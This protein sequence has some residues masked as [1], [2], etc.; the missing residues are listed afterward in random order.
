M[1]ADAVASWKAYVA[2]ADA[3]RGGYGDECALLVR[4]GLGDVVVAHFLESAEREFAAVH[5]PRLKALLEN[6]GAANISRTLSTAAEKVGNA[7]DDENEW[8]WV[9]EAVPRG[10]AELA[11]AVDERRRRAAR[12]AAAM[13]PSNKNDAD[14]ATQ[15]LDRRLCAAVGAATATVGPREMT[16]VCAAYYARAL[17]EFSRRARRARGLGDDDDSEED[18]DDR[19]VID[20]DAMEPT[21]RRPMPAWHPSCEDVMGV[22]WSRALA[23]VAG[24]LRAVG[25]GEGGASDVA[26]AALHRALETAARVKVRDVAAGDFDKKALPSLLRWLDATPLQFARCA[27]GLD[28]AGTAEWRG[29]LEYAIYERLGSLRIDEFFNVIVEFPDSLPAVDDL[30]RCLRRTTL[31]DRLTSSLRGALQRRLLIPGAPTSDIIEQYRLTIRALRAL[32]PSGVVLSVVSAP[33]KEYLRERKD[34][35][36]CVVTMLMGARDGADEL[37]GADE[38]DAM[39]VGDGDGSR[40]I[41]A[42][43]EE[44]EG[45]PEFEA[46]E[47]GRDGGAGRPDGGGGGG[48]GGADGGADGGTDGD[49]PRRRAA[50]GRGWD[51]WEPE[52]VESEA[53]SSRGR[54]RPVEDELGHLI[55]IYGSK[56]LFINEYRNMLAERLLSKVGYDVT[57]EMHTLELLKI[58]FGEASLHKCEVMLKDVLDSKRINGNVKAPPAPGTPAARDTASTNILQNSPLDATIVSALFWPPFAN[59]APDFKLPAEMKNMIDAYS[60]R[61]HHLKAPRQLMWRPTL[62]TVEVEVMRGELELQL[63]VSTMEAAVLSHFQRKD[64]WGQDELAAEMGINRATLRRKAVVWINQGLLVEE[65]NEGPDGSSYRLTTGDDGRVAFGAAAADD[66]GGGG[67]AVASAEDQA[68]AGMK[69]YEQYVI[70]M[71][72][73]FPSLPP[74]RIHNMLKMFVQDPPYDRSLDQL[75]AFLGQLVAEDKLALEGNQYSKR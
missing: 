69:V 48:D 8:S 68:A 42:P 70:G 3:D 36:R 17:K 64:R 38:D 11:A 6:H 72:T 5:L 47:D 19:I 18:D 16:G 45:D 23:S 62:G 31:H 66:E 33:L 25:G 26:E 43:P 65:K 32:D 60:K 74:D 39:D 56:E 44:W 40:L 67:G 20:D 49:A 10:V 41:A 55:N 52:P 14:D 15:T 2:A 61:Y 37:L 28:E 13:H 29:R 27:L 34:T 35:I 50:T 58:R 30:R 7:G 46:D 9:D 71:L 73:N 22:A 1:A 53:A 54:R 57:R 59:E 63:S 24:G 51:A 21:R 75:E 4:R 12:L